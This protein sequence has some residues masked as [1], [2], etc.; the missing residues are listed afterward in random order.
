M[1]LQLRRW[2]DG[3][4]PQVIDGPEATGRTREKDYTQSWLKGNDKAHFSGNWMEIHTKDIFFKK[5]VILSKTLPYPKEGK[6]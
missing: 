3:A 2:G 6:L 4:L 1:T 5:K